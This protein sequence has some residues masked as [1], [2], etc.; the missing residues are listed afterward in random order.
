MEVM[1]PRGCTAVHTFKIPGM[2][3]ASSLNVVLVSYMQNGKIVVEKTTQ[4]VS[5]DDSVPAVVVPLTQK[6]TLAFEEKGEITVQVRM[7]TNAGEAI[8]T[9]ILAGSADKVLNTGVI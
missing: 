1:I 2:P 6:D 9:T 8:K 5:I 4:W 7:L 3:A